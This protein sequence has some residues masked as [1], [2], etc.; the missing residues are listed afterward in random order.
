MSNRKKCMFDANIFDMV[1]A[2]P[3]SVEM[4]RKCVDVYVTHVQ[5]N[6]IDDTKSSHPEKW[7][8]LNWARLQVVSEG[9]QSSGERVVPTKSSAWDITE[10]NGGEWTSDDNLIYQFTGPISPNKTNPKPYK[11]KITDALIAETAIKN[12]FTLVTEDKRLRKRA[13]ALG[14]E[15]M[16]W[17]Q[18]LEYCTS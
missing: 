9:S 8:K 5:S 2:H 13:S 10:W 17:E 7:E 4:L 16:S 14:A 11:R 15:C 18:L 3:E 12:G 1:V 6:Q